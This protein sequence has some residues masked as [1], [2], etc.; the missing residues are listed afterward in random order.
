MKKHHFVNMYLTTT[1]SVMLVLLLLGAETIIMLSADN[2]VRQTRENLALN[3][4]LGEET[5]SLQLQQM[6]ALLSHAPYCLSYRYIS[7]DDALREHIDA[8]GEDPARFLGYNPLRASYELHL[9][10]Q[11]TAVDS[12]ETIA[13]RME[14]L[15]WVD[16]VVYQR[17]LIELMNRNVGHLTIV[18]V[19]AA[20]MML[21]IAMVLIINTVRL[22]IYSKRFLIGTM[23]LVGATAWHI[24]SP[25]VA[26]YTLLG[27]IAAILAFGLLGGLVYYVR[28]RFG[29]LLFELT[30]QNLAWL[31]GVLLTVGILI[32]VLA[33]MFATGRYIR[34]R[35]DALYE[36]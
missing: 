9:C 32:C 33:S 2:L 31:A 20:L 28:V 25:F 23:A 34:M 30:W 11:Y 5:D 13:H 22:Q 4:V 24:R 19:S 12:V 14:Q 7:Q 6:D 36:I 35:S 18:L 27:A 21:L 1:I 15:P 3:V 8:L 29:F 16:R 17:D 26:R 10:D